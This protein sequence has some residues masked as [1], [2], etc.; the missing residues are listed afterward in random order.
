MALTKKQHEAFAKFF[1]APTRTGLRDLLKGNIGE[2]D[3]LDF[4]E[5]WPEWVKLAKHILAMANSGGGAI[6]V[7]VKQ[8]EDG[9]V[10]AI[11]L[12]KLV[13][14]SDISKKVAG[15]IPST[16]AIE[17]LDFSYTES[18]YEKIKGKSF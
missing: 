9:T 11:G 12:T 4:K 13:D 14:K 18:E 8:Y 15:Y 7:G 16:V 17:I 1:E 3:Y 5:D 2:T 6:V 10:E